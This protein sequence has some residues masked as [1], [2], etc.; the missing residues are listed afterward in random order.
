MPNLIQKKE[1]KQFQVSDML[2]VI[3]KMNYKRMNNIQFTNAEKYFFKGKD[4]R[5]IINLLK[6]KRI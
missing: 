3:D 6:N 2:T 4:F 5:H 1:R